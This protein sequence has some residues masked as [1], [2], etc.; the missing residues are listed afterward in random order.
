MGYPLLV[1]QVGA[2]KP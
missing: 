1:H 2:K